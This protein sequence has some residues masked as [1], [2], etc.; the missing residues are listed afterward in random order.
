MST[1]LEAVGNYVPLGGI[2]QVGGGVGGLRGLVGTFTS[3]DTDAG[4]ASPAGA[5][6]AWMA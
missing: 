6:L 5:G 2:E 3:W 4:K 1:T